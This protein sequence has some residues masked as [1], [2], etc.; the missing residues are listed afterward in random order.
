MYHC[1][2]ILFWGGHISAKYSPPVSDN[3]HRPQLTVALAGPLAGQSDPSGKSKQGNPLRSEQILKNNHKNSLY[4]YM[5]FGRPLGFLMFT[6]SI[7]EGN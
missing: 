1:Y 3:V 6:F 7:H 5:I 4:M 2:Q